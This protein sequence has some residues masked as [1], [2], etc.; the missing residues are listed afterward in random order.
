MKFYY[1]GGVFRSNAQ[2]DV[3]TSQYAS[4]LG[5]FTKNFSGVWHCKKIKREVTA[6]TILPC[7]RRSFIVYTWRHAYFKKMQS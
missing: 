5:G 1:K 6:C 7:K 3:Y 4:W 2:T